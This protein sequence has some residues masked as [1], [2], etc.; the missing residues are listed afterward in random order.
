MASA[1]V[2]RRWRHC[3][4]SHFSQCLK[5]ANTITVGIFWTNLYVKSDENSRSYE[6]P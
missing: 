4:H 6:V 5:Y 1:E 3:N 2:G